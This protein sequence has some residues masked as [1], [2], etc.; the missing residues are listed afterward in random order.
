[1]QTDRNS[2][3]NNARGVKEAKAAIKESMMDF[4][5]H[6]STA[7]A[8]LAGFYI[9]TCAFV[10]G[11]RADSLGTGAFNFLDD[12]LLQGTA[13]T[14]LAIDLLSSFNLDGYWPTNFRYMILIFISLFLLSLISYGSFLRVGM[15]QAK[16]YKAG[17][18]DREEEKN[19]LV[20]LQR[21]MNSLFISLVLGFVS[22]PWSLLR[23]AFDQALSLTLL[24]L[25]LVILG[26]FIVVKGYNTI[27]SI[28]NR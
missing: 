17:I 14:N 28:I 8:I 16:I 25:T 12:Q 7:S 6:F 21:G 13:F 22:L 11:V 19:Q 10:I 26:L 4:V 2:V 1:M 20:W 5:G 18:V 27:R 3:N 23:F 24:L 9:A 15:I